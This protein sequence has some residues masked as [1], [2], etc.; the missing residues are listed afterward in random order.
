MWGDHLQSLEPSRFTGPARIELQGDVV[1]GAALIPLARTLLGGLRQRLVLGGIDSGAYRCQLNGATIT[2]VCGIGINIARILVPAEGAASVSAGAHGFTLYPKT[3]TEPY[4]IEHR[5]SAAIYPVDDAAP[6]PP[7]AWMKLARVFN[8]QTHQV[9][10]T[11]SSLTVA[12][13]GNQFVTV[14]LDVYS[15]WHSPYGD[16]P[17]ANLGKTVLPWEPRE[18]GPYQPY[19]YAAAFTY[20]DAGGGKHRPPQVVYRNGVPWQSLHGILPSES[21]I[22]GVMVCVVTVVRDGIPYVSSRLL[23]AYTE[24]YGYMRTAILAFEVHGD[25]LQP[26]DVLGGWSYSRIA[27]PEAMCLLYPIRFHPNGLEFHFMDGSLDADQP[28][29]PYVSLFLATLTHQVDSV[30][31]ASP[32]R[33]RYFPGIITNQY[34]DDHPTTVIGDPAGDG[35]TTTTTVGSDTHSTRRWEIHYRTEQDDQVGTSSDYQGELYPIGLSYTANGDLK[36]AWA[37]VN[38][39]V[40]AGR[41]DA[42]DW[43]QI[44][45]IASSSSDQVWHVVS[46]P[47]GYYEYETRFENN[48]EQVHQ[49]TLQRDTGTQQQLHLKVGDYEEMV[50]LVSS[51]E[52]EGSVYREKTVDHQDSHDHYTYGYYGPGD[53]GKR[54]IEPY[55][56]NQTSDYTATLTGTKTS[57]SDSSALS[58]YYVSAAH[59]CVFYALQFASFTT[60]ITETGNKTAYTHIYNNDR[61]SGCS[62][63]YLRT[64][65]TGG[66]SRYQL[67]GVIAGKVVFEDVQQETTEQS[68]VTYT[69]D[70]RFRCD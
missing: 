48:G 7:P 69:E 22:A 56:F 25:R 42:S 29:R 32:V 65:T 59:D 43:T 21:V 23:V 13:A 66:E 61:E 31:V 4:G 36:I 12:L 8:A 54:Q 38:G 5:A 17:M 37:A 2:V 50:S 30:T 41:V 55:V 70:P 53:T 35:E 57:R 6:L 46:A 16:G 27:F 14:G 44:D 60:T 33:T 62:A 1:R 3:D 64:T 49:A 63:S 26:L 24:Y 40:A 11:P 39:Q 10:L 19:Y 18:T 51:S 28:T 52:E 9:T 58:L 34:Y 68:T 20:R 45:S 15:W 67:K 47:R